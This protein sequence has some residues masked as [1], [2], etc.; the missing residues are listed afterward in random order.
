MGAALYLLIWGIRVENGQLTV[1]F[2]YEIQFSK[3]RARRMQNYER[4][5]KI[6]N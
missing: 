3:P 4:V 1:T 2:K 6:L 5:L